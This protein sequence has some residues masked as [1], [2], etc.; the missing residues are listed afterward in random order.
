MRWHV[1]SCITRTYQL[2]LTEQTRLNQHLHEFADRHSFRNFISRMPPKPNVYYFQAEGSSIYKV[3]YYRADDFTLHKLN[4]DLPPRSDQT[5]DSLILANAVA[6]AHAVLNRGPLE[7]LYW[8]SDN[9]MKTWEVHNIDLTVRRAEV[10]YVRPASGIMGPGGEEV[11]DTPQLR[12]PRHIPHL[13]RR[14][15]SEPILEFELGSRTGNH[16]D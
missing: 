12:T 1:L 6:R 7:N 8:R 4:P 16:R 10:R 5:F 3:F 15:K 14:T 9:G 11:G 13:P 2:P